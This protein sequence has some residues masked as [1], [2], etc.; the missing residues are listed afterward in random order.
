MLS[1]ENLAV[2]K[3]WCLTLLSFIAKPLFHQET[4]QTVLVVL[5]IIYTLIRIFKE[6]RKPK[7]T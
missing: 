4:L 7:K 5:S 3:V 1:H 6:I 2:V